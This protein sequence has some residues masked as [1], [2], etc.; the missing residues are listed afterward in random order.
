MVIMITIASHVIQVPIEDIAY[1]NVNVLQDIMMMAP[2]KNV[3]PAQT[4]SIT[5]ILIMNAE[6][7]II[8]GLFKAINL[9]Y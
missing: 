4:N 9:N 5:L 6:I 8:H 2:M 7:V 3:D 1:M